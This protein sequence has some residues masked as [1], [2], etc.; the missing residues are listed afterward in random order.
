[1]SV[2]QKKQSNVENTILALLVRRGCRA[3]SEDDLRNLCPKTFNFKEAM[4]RLV[5][6]DL[7]VKWKSEQFVNYIVE[8]SFAD[9]AFYEETQPLDPLRCLFGQQGRVVV[10]RSIP[11]ITLEDDEE[12][13]V[14]RHNRY[15]KVA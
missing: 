10:Q 2:S 4:I 8:A 9:G 6:K 15:K 3:I 14:T 12:T 5:R 7:V 1:M 13:E 11:F